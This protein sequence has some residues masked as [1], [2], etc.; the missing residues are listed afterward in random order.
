LNHGP[1]ARSNQAIAKLDEIASVIRKLVAK[2]RHVGSGGCDSSTS[3][4]LIRREISM[5]CEVELPSRGKK[6]EP[7][8]CGKPASTYRMFGQIASVQATLC[9]SHVE[10]MRSKGYKLE[11]VDPMDHERVAS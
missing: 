7:T 8:P 6:G 11:P 5:K 1:Y 3:P 10:L 2:H 9:V 4:T